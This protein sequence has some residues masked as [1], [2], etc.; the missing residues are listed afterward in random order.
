MS[1]PTEYKSDEGKGKVYVVFIMLSIQVKY[2]VGTSCIIKQK[3]F[4]L[5]HRI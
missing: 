1:Y 5:S 4:A 3:K 2:S